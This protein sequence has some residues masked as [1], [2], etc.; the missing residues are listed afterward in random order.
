[1]RAQD[2]EFDVAWRKA[3][4]IQPIERSLDMDSILGTVWWS[5]LMFVAGAWIG[6]P[7]FSWVWKKLPFGS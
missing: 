1:M 4:T 7:L 3:V 5:A 6:R 2:P